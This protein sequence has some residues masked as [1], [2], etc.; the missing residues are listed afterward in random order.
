MK[1]F[2]KQ[3]RAFTLIELLVVIAIIAILAA[4]LLPALA[5]AKARAQRIA[6]VNDLKQVGLAFR[7][8]EGD[9]NDR[10]PMA[11]PAAQGGCSDTAVGFAAPGLIGTPG[12]FALNFPLLGPLGVF[13]MFVVMSNELNTPK[14]LACPSEY[15]TTR[16]STQPASVWGNSGTVAP[17]TLGFFQDLQSSYFVGVDAI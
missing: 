14:I 6:C 10:Y 15:Q 1:K 8:W 9:N 17:I 3:I 16:S 12:N 2:T 7:V 13:G 5:K 11:V 4:M